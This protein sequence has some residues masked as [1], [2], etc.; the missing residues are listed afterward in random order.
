MPYKYHCLDCDAIIMAEKYPRPCL[1]PKCKGDDMD[2]TKV[3][4]TAQQY[5]ERTNEIFEN[6]TE[7][8]TKAPTGIRTNCKTCKKNYTTHPAVFQDNDGCYVIPPCPIC[9]TKLSLGPIH[10][11]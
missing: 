4:E 5:I 7:T 8:A 9:N 11:V 3:T 2:A 10:H 1:C 6:I